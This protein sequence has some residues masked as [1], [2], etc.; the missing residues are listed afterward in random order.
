MSDYAP[1]WTKVKNLNRELTCNDDIDTLL[2]ELHTGDI[3]FFTTG[4]F[5]SIVSFSIEMGCNSEWT[6]CG[7]VVRKPGDSAVYLFESVNNHVAESQFI[8]RR[9]GKHATGMGVRL[10]DLKEYMHYGYACLEQKTTRS[11]IFGLLLLDTTQPGTAEFQ[12]QIVDYVFNQSMCVHMIYPT[13]IYPLVMAWWDGWESLFV[14]CGCFDTYQVELNH[15]TLASSAVPTQHSHYRRGDA[16][17]EPK[18]EEIFCS[19]LIIRVFEATDFFRSDIPCEEWV[20]EDLAHGINLNVW[21]RQQ[22]RV[23][24]YGKLIVKELSCKKDL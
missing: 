18:D 23:A 10:I 22:P 9:T 16:N 24:Y 5:H 6:H 3:M 1:G 2:E 15:L 12:R 21:F 13:T 11:C 20:V 7:M 8:D 19:Q 17:K 4:L 14:C